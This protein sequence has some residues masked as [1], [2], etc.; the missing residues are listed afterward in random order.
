MAQGPSHYLNRL[1]TLLH[2]RMWEPEPLSGRRVFLNRQL[3]IFYLAGKGYIGDLIKLHALALAF[4]TVLSLVPFLVVCFSL[5]K[6]LGVHN[7]LQPFL[8]EI[9]SP[10]G[11]GGAEVSRRLIGFVNNVNVN[12]LGTAGIVTLFVMVLSVMGSAEE[13]FNQI[14]RVKTPRRFS[15]RFSDYLSVLL[16]GPVLLFAALAVTASLQS[17]GLVRQLAVLRPFGKLIVLLL[18]LTPYLAMWGTFTFM[19]IFIPNTRVK[20]RSAAFG[21]FVAALLWQTIGWGFA[22]FVA[23]STEYTAVYSSFAVLI[24]FLLWIN[25][26]WI[27]VLFGAEVAFAHQHSDFYW[28]GRGDYQNSPAARERLGLQVMALIGLHFYAGKPPWTVEDLARR[29]HLPQDMIADFLFLFTRS[30]LLIPAGDA[31]CVPARD[32]EQIGVREILAAVRGD[33]DGRQIKN[34]GDGLDE[35]MREVD[36]SVAAALRGKSLKSLVLSLSPPEPVG[37]SPGG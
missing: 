25:I 22:A 33:D 12:A 28:E 15:R 7:R 4:K 5:L 31:S 9:L 18:R 23:S 8:A 20:L 3:R 11:A 37:E 29:L 1:K 6:A 26:G 34:E 13:A 30:G 36:G 14:W 27:I 17:H 16:V 19:Y 10:M 2:Q 32:L 21:G 24:V 35:L